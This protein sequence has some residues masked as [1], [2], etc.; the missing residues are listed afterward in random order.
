MST[1]RVCLLLVLGVLSNYEH[2]T[3][4]HKITES[5]RSLEYNRRFP[6]A[7]AG[8]QGGHRFTGPGFPRTGAW[9]GR[10]GQC[11]TRS[12]SGGGR[13]H[14]GN[15]S[16]TW[17]IGKVSNCF[18]LFC[19]CFFLCVCSFQMLPGDNYVQRITVHSATKQQSTTCAFSFFFATAYFMSWKSLTWVRDVAP[20]SKLQIWTNLKKKHLQGHPH[21]ISAC[22]KWLPCNML[23]P[24]SQGLGYPSHIAGAVPQLP[25][26]PSRLWECRTLDASSRSIPCQRRSR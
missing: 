21:L 16:K 14:S 1:C 26:F 11:R 22:T 18:L 7:L 8:L 5:F 12:C 6:P 25:R 3:G 15:V 2:C 4:R 23:S 10:I 9:S 20:T 24:V 17:R 19:C 13:S